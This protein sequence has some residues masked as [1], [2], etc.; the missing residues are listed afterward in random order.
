MCISTSSIADGADEAASNVA[1]LDDIAVIHD[2]A[3]SAIDD[4]AP[5]CK[6]VVYFYIVYVVY[7]NK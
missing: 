7:F 4:V 6:K 5:L 1:V 3:P 2:V